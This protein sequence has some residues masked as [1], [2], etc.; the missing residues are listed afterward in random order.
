MVMARPNIFGGMKDVKVGTDA[1]Y[2][3]AGNYWVRVD[4]MKQGE[5]RSNTPN[6]I[7]E[8][9]VV[10]TICGWEPGTHSRC[11]RA[12]EPLL[13]RE[14][15]LLQARIEEVFAGGAFSDRFT[16]VDPM[17]VDDDDVAAACG[18]K[19]V[20]VGG[21][22]A[23]VDDMVPDA[24]GALTQNQPLRGFVLEYNN[25]MTRGKDKQGPNGVMIEGKWYTRYKVIRRVLPDEVLTTLSPDDV[26]RFFPAGYLQNELQV[27]TQ[28]GVI[29]Q[30]FTR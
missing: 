9:T 20:L 24:N 15:Q 17:T 11:R 4:K 25:I 30:P 2:L 29:K 1:N 7:V 10:R 16:I 8:Q 6:V 18:K 13:R 23:L 19:I 12:G 14:G 21:I 5:T 26:G 22:Q 3:G 28:H 27:L